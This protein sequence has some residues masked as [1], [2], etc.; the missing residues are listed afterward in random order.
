M[1][2]SA[3][4]LR[5]IALS[6]LL[7]LGLGP[8]AS[9]GGKAG[10]MGMVTFHLETED[11]GNPK[12]VSPPQMYEGKER[13]FLRTPEISMKDVVAFS[14]F[15]SGAGEEYGIVFQLRE[16]AKRRL[17]AISQANQGKFLLAQVNG[18]FVDGVLIDKP[19]EDGL[20]VVWKGLSAEDVKLFDNELPRIGEDGKKKKKKKDD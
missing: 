19:V 14:P 1:L 8:A 12:M 5:I 11:G 16:A 2:R 15:P 6:G 20:I 10:E 9:A 18:R 3:M 17:T 4:H 7:T 13:F